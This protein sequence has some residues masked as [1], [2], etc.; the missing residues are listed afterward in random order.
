MFHPH[1]ACHSHQEDI[2]VG[3]GNNSG[4]LIEKKNKDIKISLEKFVLFEKIS[5][6][7]TDVLQDILNTCQKGSFNRAVQSLRG[8]HTE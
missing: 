6:P 4:V 5:Q 1:L 8:I 3:Q 7:C 2:P